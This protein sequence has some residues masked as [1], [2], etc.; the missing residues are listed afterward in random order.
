MKLRDFEF[1]VAAILRQISFPPG[2]GAYHSWAQQTR[3]AHLQV[4]LFPYFCS[5]EGSF[6]MRRQ[7]PFPNLPLRQGG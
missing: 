7:N 6:Q 1:E 3:S 5:L 2:F 4:F